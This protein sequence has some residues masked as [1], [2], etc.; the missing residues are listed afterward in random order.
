MPRRRSTEDI[1]LL[2]GALFVLRRKCG[3]PTCRCATGEPHETPALA[4]PAGAARRRS[5][6]PTP[7]SR[8]CAPHSCAT[9]RPR[10]LS[11]PRPTLGSPRCRPRLPAPEPARDGEP[12]R[13]GL[14]GAARAGGRCVHRSLVQLV[15]RVGLGLGVRNGSAH[16][17][18]D[19]G[20]DGPRHALGARR[21]PPLGAGRSFRPRGSLDGD[22]RRGGRAP[23]SRGTCDLLSRR[24]LVPSRR[25]QGGRCGQLPGR[26]ALD[27]QPRR[28]WLRPQPRRARCPDRSPWAGC[29][30]PCPSGWHCTAREEPSSPLSQSCS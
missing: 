8:L 3:K 9:R 7:I 17:L 28:V 16:R 20:G 14:E 2:R 10:P 25:S 23:R 6:L 21:I 13:V 15:L 18:L 26:G 22:G 27:S 24:H 11:T 1:Q 5:R 4:Y 30:S 29:L 12:G 19:G